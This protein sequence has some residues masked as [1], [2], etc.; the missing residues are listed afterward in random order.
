M[1]F[2][3]GVEADHYVA[4]SPA[5]P[6]LDPQFPEGHRTFLGRRRGFQSR[7]EQEELFVLK[8]E[9]ENARPSKKIRPANRLQ[10]S[11]FKLVE[12]DHFQIGPHNVS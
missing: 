1:T 12:S 10:K 9:Q 5:A 2:D 11:T 4:R 8:M 7:K 3:V 6:W